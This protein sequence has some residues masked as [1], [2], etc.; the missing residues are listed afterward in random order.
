[1]GGLTKYPQLIDLRFG[2]VSEMDDVFN[3]VIG[4]WLA[5]EPN[6]Q[7]VFL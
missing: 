3:L 4:E 1:M 5:N 2:G 7:F 6:L